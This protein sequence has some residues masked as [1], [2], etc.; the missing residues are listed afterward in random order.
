LRIDAKNK[1][2]YHVLRVKR[3]YSHGMFSV[4][5]S[6][7]VHASSQGIHLNIFWTEVSGMGRD[8]SSIVP[9]SQTGRNCEFVYHLLKVDAILY[10][11]VRLEVSRGAL[12]HN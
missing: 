12:V 4:C 5:D 6:F 8:G 9:L 10:N 1:K 3:I 11:V 2:K 7:V